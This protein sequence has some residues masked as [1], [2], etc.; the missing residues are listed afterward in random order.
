MVELENADKRSHHSHSVHDGGPMMDVVLGMGDEL[1]ADVQ[2]IQIDVGSDIASVTDRQSLLGA[3]SVA[4]EELQ[5]RAQLQA[6]AAAEED[7]R[8]SLEREENTPSPKKRGRI[9]GGIEGE[10]GTQEEVVGRKII[11]K[12][13]KK[14]RFPTDGIDLVL[15]EDEEKSYKQNKKKIK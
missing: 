2:P 12:K 3:A 8:K 6:A 1:G 13:I 9:G 7:E 14:K 5:K 10:L 4:T 11:K 15:D